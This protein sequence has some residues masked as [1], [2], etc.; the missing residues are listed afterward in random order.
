MKAYFFGNFMLSS[1]QQGI[2][3]AHVLAEMMLEYSNPANTDGQILHEW[4]SSHKT[5]QLMNGGNQQDL[6]EL[7][8]FFETMDDGSLPWGWFNEDFNSLN[9]CLTSVG[10]VVPDHITKL[11]EESG[12]KPVS[13]KL[14]GI[15][16][17]VLIYHEGSEIVEIEY[18]SFEIQLADKL[19]KYRYAN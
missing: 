17:N 16:N 14:V 6:L 4:A 2:Q 18:T 11:T 15:D 13:S 7:K 8:S 1:I 10:I 19:K 12:R 5:I 9:D 3:A